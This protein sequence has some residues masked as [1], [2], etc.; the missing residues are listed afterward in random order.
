MVMPNIIQGFGLEIMMI[1]IIGYLCVQ[2]FRNRK[3][4]T[5]S[6]FFYLS[7]SLMLFL[8]INV[9]VRISDLRLVTWDATTVFLLNALYIALETLAVYEWF[10]YFLTVQGTDFSRRIRNSHYS[11]IPLYGMIILLAVSFK[12]GWLF[13]VDGDGIYHRGNL[14]FLQL[15]LPYSYLAASFI[16]TIVGYKANRNRRLL[17]IFLSAFFSSVAASVLQVLFS[18]SFTHAGLT[19]AVILIYIEM[20]QYEIKQIENM[21]SLREVN[22]KLEEVNGKLSETVRELEVSVANEKAANN[23]KNDFLSRMSH[24]IRTPLNGILGII[25][26]DNRHPEDTELLAANRKKAKVAADHLLSLINDILD[27]S[28]L[29][30]G[31]YEFSHEPFSMPGLLEE[32]FTITNTSAARTGITLTLEPDVPG[33]PA[34]YGS[35]LHIK[36]ILLNIVG[37]AIKYN[38]E[39]GSV[40]IRLTHEMIGSDKAAYTVT[41]ADTGIGMSEEYLKNLFEPFSQESIDARSVYN[42]S[43]LGMAIT[44][45]LI[46]N[47]GGTI[48]VESRVGEGS[49]FTVRLVL[50]IAEEK[51]LCEEAAGEE[52]NLNGLRILLAEDNELNID[53]AKS[54][55]EDYGAEVEVAE[56]GE[57]AVTAFRDAPEGTYDVILMD[58]MMPVMDGY[59]ATR[60]IRSLSRPD[61]RT[62]PILAMTANAFA[63]DV[64]HCLE[65]GM[66]DHLAK[67]FEIGKV[68][69]TI[70]RF[71]RRGEE[72]GRTV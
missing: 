64:K 13:Y 39:N 60:T 53:I 19:L 6:S 45:A 72:K 69:T 20:F 3:T 12:T 65:A 22:Q 18:G 36:Q 30:S 59:E 70:N 21:K 63:D 35:P 34:T 10:V 56:N 2:S 40:R 9:P 62:I 38:K 33:A 1:A 27:M 61:A 26:I 4:E 52:E 7:L 17:T 47:M 23:A 16:C 48:G 31:K 57:L 8:L 58:C 24:D 43:G 25:E 66:N 67:P 41:V 50:D 37:N 28:K 54:L 42:G 51:A 68:V 49:T 71:V 55:L 11:L 29:A 15:L 46:D 32:V 14:F 5:L 44:K